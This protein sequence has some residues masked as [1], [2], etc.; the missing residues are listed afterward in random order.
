M[1]QLTTFSILFGLLCLTF[2]HS[3]SKTPVV[4]KEDLKYIGCQVCEHMVDS[5]K[6]TLDDMKTKS[7]T[8]KLNELDILETI[9]QI[10]NPHNETGDWIKTLDIV[11]STNK[12]LSYLKLEAPGGVSKCG[13]E[14]VTIAKSCEMLLDND[15][16]A[17]DLANAF[18]KKPS[19]NS[20]EMQVHMCISVYDTIHYLTR[21]FSFFSQ[22]K[23]C[24]TMSS[25]CKKAAPHVDPKYK[26][27]DKKF[28]A[29]EEKDIEMEK[30]MAS[31]KSTL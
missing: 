9:E 28:K 22:K 12:G 11:E 27:I 23:V 24:H 20:K 16:D 25:R 2:V 13:D 15:L 7:P 4:S 8:N 14:C 3:A 31:M 29:M 10:C 17:D 30:L 6:H 18:I 21:F 26:R 19:F 5:L 1:R